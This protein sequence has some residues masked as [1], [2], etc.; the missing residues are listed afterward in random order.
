M[1]VGKMVL[2]TYVI[3]AMTVTAATG[4]DPQPPIHPQVS[5]DRPDWENPAVNAINKLP[6]RAAGFPFEN[7]PMALARD[8]N[9]SSRFLADG[10]WKFHF[11]PNVDQR[12]KA[13]H[14]P[15]TSEETSNEQS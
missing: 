5:P 7:P 9:A 4:A 3:G 11:S 15:V 2:M 1:H 13:P 8:P 14:W 6:A 10:S 12:P